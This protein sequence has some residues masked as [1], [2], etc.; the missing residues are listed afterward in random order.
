MLLRSRAV[1][2]LLK[3]ALAVVDEDE[4]AASSNKGSGWGGARF[5]AHYDHGGGALMFSA[6]RPISTSHL[7]PLRLGSLPCGVVA[8][9]SVVSERCECS[10]R[11]RRAAHGHTPRKK[12]KA[13]F[14]LAPN[15]RSSCIGA[16][17]DLRS[18]WS[19]SALRRCVVSAKSHRRGE[20]RVCG[21]TS[22]FAHR[23]FKS[24]SVS[25]HFAPRARTV[26]ISSSN[27]FVSRCE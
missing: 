4:E 2:W 5:S 27:H 20:A 12:A 24:P 13:P 1:C 21:S 22:F 16:H 18:V 7:A 11:R 17:A 19:A 6:P 26:T 9:R 23:F 10:C 15:D 25:W 3:Q 8:R 14:S